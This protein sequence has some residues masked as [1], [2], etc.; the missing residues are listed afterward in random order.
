VRTK[1]LRISIRIL[2]SVRKMKM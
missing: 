2:I 1:I